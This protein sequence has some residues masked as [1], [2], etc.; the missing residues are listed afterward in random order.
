MR[1]GEDIDEQESKTPVTKKPS[2]SDEP[3]TE[4]GQ[5]EGSGQTIEIPI[6]FVGGKEFKAGDELVLKVVSVEDGK[7]EVEYATGSDEEESGAPPSA[8]DEIDAMAAQS[9]NY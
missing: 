7:L 3:L 2:K 4:E 1:G 6:E 9:T 8:D 5:P